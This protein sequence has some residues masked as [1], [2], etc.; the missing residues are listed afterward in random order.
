MTG[1]QKGISARFVKHQITNA[2]SW[3]NLWNLKEH[4]KISSCSGIWWFTYRLATWWR[5]TAPVWHTAML[6]GVMILLD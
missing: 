3:R 6:Y 5:A 2:T 4:T 1:R